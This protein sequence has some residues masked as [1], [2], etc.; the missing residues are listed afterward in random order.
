MQETSARLTSLCRRFTADRGLAGFTIEEVC[1]QGDVS[2]RTFF[3]YFPSKEDAVLGAN[4]DEET[5]QLAVEF[6]GRSSRGWAAV[7]D[8]LVDLV[9]DHFEA[10]GVDSVAHAE[11][12]AAIEREP[13]LLLR[14]MGISRDRD[15]QV[16]ELVALREKTGTDDPHVEASVS[17]LSTLIRTAGDAFLDPDN[18]RD[19]A[20]ILRESLAAMRTVLASPTPRKATQ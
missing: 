8:D 16:V 1:E 18:T 13:R 14:F 12:V 20:D 15:R 2:R 10:V 7:L 3:N 4:P 9:I 19:F 11:F 6:L 17:I 5:E